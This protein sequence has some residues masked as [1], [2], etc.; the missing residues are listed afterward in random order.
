[1]PAITT[2]QCRLYSGAPSMHQCASSARTRSTPLSEISPFLIHGFWATRNTLS[3]NP[4]IWYPRTAMIGYETFKFQGVDYWCAK[5]QPVTVMH[6]ISHIFGGSRGS[7][8][9]YKQI[10]LRSHLIIDSP[11]KPVLCPSTCVPIQ[12]LCSITHIT[13]RVPLPLPYRLAGYLLHLTTLR[14]AL[15]SLLPISVPCI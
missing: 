6:V 14:S 15:L 7:Q 9:S 13:C 10:D 11:P 8:A 1:M 5:L 2:L 4:H 12:L 3:R